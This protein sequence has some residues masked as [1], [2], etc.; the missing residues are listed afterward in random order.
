MRKQ[1]IIISVTVIL[2][3]SFIS[4]TTIKRKD[5]ISVNGLKLEYKGKP[6][7]FAGV[8]FWYACYLGATEEGRERLKKELDTLNALGLTNL[9]IL[10]ASEKSD[11][12]KSLKKTIQP[13][14]GVYNEDILIG[15]DYA[16]AEIGKRNMHA[17][18]FLNNYWQWSGGMA[19]YVNW[20]TGE[21]IP[22]P[23]IDNDWSAFIGYSGKFYQIP[24]AVELNRKYIKYLVTRINTVTGIPYYDDP[25]IMA[26][27]LCNEPR[28]GSWKTGN[29]NM[30]NF[31]RWIDETA[32]FIHSLDKNHLVTTGSEGIRGCMDN[33]DYFV[34]AHSSKY[35]DYTNFH[36]WPKNWMWFNPLK[37]EAT[38]ETTEIK[39]TNYIKKHIRLSEN[40]K[41][42]IT[43]EEFGIDRDYAKLDPETPDTYRQ[44]YFKSIY[45][46]V[47]D[48][49]LNGAC[50]AGTNVWSWGGFGLPHNISEIED[51]PEAYVGDQLAEP[52][53]MNTIYVSDTSTIKIICEHLSQIRKITE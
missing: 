27:E 18:I 11:L 45:S 3:I 35:I 51:N 36:L 20:T 19:Q 23:D 6:Y 46:Q 41:K 14:P 40:L 29:E 39:A 25:A 49:I 10:G 24:E 1:L 43:F 12:I 48:S 17:V 37:P 16:L 30:D 13:E 9:R 8:N 47:T 21:K 42:P 22:D 7:Y 53:G 44:K 15:L 34:R 5:F 4:G 26:W 2:V 33:D 52:Q 32:A 28:P 38:Y 50:L 31:V